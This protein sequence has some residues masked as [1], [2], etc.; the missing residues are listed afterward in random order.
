MALGAPRAG[1]P[2]PASSVSGA[3]RTIL[4][5]AETRVRLAANEIEEQGLRLLEVALW[6][7]AALL[8]LSIG[9]GFAAFFVVLLF[10]DTHRVVAVALVTA[11][12]LGAGVGGV[13][14]ARASFASRPGFLSATLAELR[15]DRDRAAGRQASER[16]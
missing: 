8:M 4:S 9:L 15:K 7:G 14:M 1:E 11:T 2:A 3:L 6:A 12:F 5:V 16:P 10:W 13:L